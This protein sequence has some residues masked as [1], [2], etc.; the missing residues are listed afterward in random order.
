MRYFYTSILPEHLIAKH[1]LSNAACNFS[2]NLISGNVFDHVFSVMGTDH[3]GVMESD[4]YEDSRYELIFSSK[5]RNLGRIGILLASIQEQW[6][7]S[8]RIVRG[9]S[10]WFY[11]LDILGLFLYIFLRLFKP[12]VKINII[13][14][15]FT[16][17]NK[18]W[19]YPSLCLHLI[20]KAD[21]NI[22]L[23]N[24]ELFRC[25]N[26]FILPGVVPSKTGSEPIIEKINKKYLLS[27]VLS[28]QISQIS[29]VLKAFSNLPQCELH[30]TGKTDN[31]DIINEYADKFQNIIWHGNVSF[32][33]YLNI[34][35]S[36]TFQLST[37]DPKFPE[38][39]CNFPS[40][41]IETLLHNRIIISTIEYTQI[42]DIK[43]FKTDSS[44]ECFKSSIENI[45]SLPECTLIKYAN[46]G[47]KVAEMFSTKVWSE[48][49]FKIERY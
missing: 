17:S 27:G 5:L 34:M 43:Y 46:Q 33:E 18:K 14:L 28:E 20:N 36:C 24:S 40:K 7:V 44:V 26:T 10:V 32:H 1:K 8:R 37:R 21:G 4:A 47:K 31:E 13:V 22:C 35:H 19:S 38:N 39:Q 29:M 23:S 45:S 15:D 2:F 12:S 41:I 9:S 6:K 3:D 30:I 49:M 11:N 25:K 16:P 48:A 42:E